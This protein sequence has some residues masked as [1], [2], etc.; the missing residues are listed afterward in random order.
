[1]AAQDELEAGTIAAEKSAILVM[2][3]FK[4]AI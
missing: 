4:P 1:M 3:K 2:L